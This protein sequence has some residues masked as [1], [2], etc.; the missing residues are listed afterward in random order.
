MKNWITIALAVIVSSLL[1][2]LGR[3]DSKIDSLK[4]QTKLQ[5]KYS[6]VDVETHSKDEIYEEKNW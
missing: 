3:K 5:D 6:K 2:I 4:D 1:Y